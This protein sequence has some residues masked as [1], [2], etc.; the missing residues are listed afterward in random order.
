MATFGEIT[1]M[2]LDLLKEH[3]DDA[4]YTEEHIIFLASKMRALLLERKYKNS[5]RMMFQ[6]MSDE[7]IQEICLDLEPAEMLPNG[8][9]GM[10]LKSV[11]KIPSALTMYAPKL[12]V[13]S[14]MIFTNVTYIAPER[15][16]YVGHNKWLKNIIYAA[17]SNDGHVYLNSVNPQ[18]IHLKEARMTGVFANPEE[19]AKFS[20]VED[21]EVKNCDKLLKKFPLEESL[22]PSCL[23]LIVQ[24][25]VGSRYA[26]ED[27]GN[28][29]KDGLGDAAVT[30]Q[31][32][33]TPVESS[34]PKK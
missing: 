28:D 15:M 34:E 30:S 7:N 14:D 16:P 4:Y 26:P 8:C 20:C 9:A 23:E 31:K 33:A 24:E 6:T 17:R 19:A 13:V 11:Q 10:W 12:S 25:L 32:A 22:I 27:K 21:G 18:F 3:A 1:Y 29:A 5:N 2:V